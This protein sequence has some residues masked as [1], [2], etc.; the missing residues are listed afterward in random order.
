MNLKPLIVYA[1]PDQNSFN[2]QVLTSIEKFFQQKKLNY[3]VLDLYQDGFNPVISIEELR[4]HFS[5]DPQVQNY[6]NH[7]ISSNIFIFIYPDWWG[8]PP[9][10]L[11]GFLDRVFAQGVAY[12][13][14]GDEEGGRVLKPLFNEKAIIIFST[15]DQLKNNAYF[16]EKVWINQI[17]P[18]CGSKQFEFHCFYHIRESDYYDRM[19]WLNSLPQIL[20]K[21]FTN[22]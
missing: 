5:F 17:L 7:V 2:H 20:L 21:Y 3:V 15:T 22:T 8:G 6:K 16:P 14:V 19:Q 18:F 10:I 1:H 13:L 11:K 12:E 4:S 9:A